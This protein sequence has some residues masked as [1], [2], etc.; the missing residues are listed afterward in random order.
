MLLIR[1]AKK[2]A[3]DRT[4]TER[5]RLNNL[6]PQPGARRPNKRK[7]RGYG[8]GQVCGKDTVFQCCTVYS[9]PASLVQSF[10]TWYQPLGVLQSCKR[11]PHTSHP[12]YLG[13]ENLKTTLT[14]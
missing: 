1:A 9:S 3:E 5:L 12:A 7:G 10:W 11:G 14:R 6:S 4:P 8:A 2:E 13:R